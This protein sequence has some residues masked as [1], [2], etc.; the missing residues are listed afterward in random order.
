MRQGWRESACS[1]EEVTM[2]AKELHA[3]PREE[4]AD[5]WFSFQCVF[6]SVLYLL[7]ASAYYMGIIHVGY[8]SSGA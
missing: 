5:S 1:L 8:L 2:R 7:Q 3:E 4:D 6:I